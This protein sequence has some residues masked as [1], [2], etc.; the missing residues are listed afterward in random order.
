L[1]LKRTIQY[2]FFP[3]NIV[4]GNIISNLLNLKINYTG[5]FLHLIVLL[6]FK[7]HFTPFKENGQAKVQGSN[8]DG[9]PHINAG[10]SLPILQNQTKEERGRKGGPIGG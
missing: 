5:R 1:L 2:Y 8:F 6:I 4:L 9:E 10:K 3:K 7:S